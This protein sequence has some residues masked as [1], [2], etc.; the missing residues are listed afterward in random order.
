MAV[1]TSNAPYQGGVTVTA[2]DSTVLGRTRAIWVGGAG[3][4]AVKMADGDIIVFIGI[5]AGTMLPISVTQVRSTSTTATNI[6]AL[7]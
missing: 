1:I 2:S 7:R 4:M 5:T 3:N 6:L